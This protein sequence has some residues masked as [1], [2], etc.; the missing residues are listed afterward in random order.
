MENR[1]EYGQNSQGGRLSAESTGTGIPAEL[2]AEFPATGIPAE[3]TGT[4]ISAK[5]SAE[6]PAA[7]ISAE[8]TGTGIPT[9]LSAKFPT[10]GI[11]TESTAG[12]STELSATAISEQKIQESRCIGGAL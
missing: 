11:P 8:S 6:F 9:E 12:I 5:L 7:G 4:G 1:E 3:S 10:T 2:S